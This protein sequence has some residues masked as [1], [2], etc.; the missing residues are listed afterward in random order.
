VIHRRPAG[1]ILALA[2]ATLASA[3]TAAAP[4]LEDPE[5]TVVPELVVRA[6]VPGPAWWTVRK[7]DRV[8]YILGLPDAP[9]P[10][11]LKWDLGAL[12]RRLAGASVLITPI[13]PKAG[14]GD[15]PAFLRM[16][17]ELKSRAPMEQGLPEAL[18][19]RF[20]AARTRL[21]KPASRYAGWDA[22]LAGQILVNDFQGA[23]RMTTKE[24]LAAVRRAAGRAGV[25]VR[26][27]ASFR[28][29]GLLDPA[30]RNLTP[31]ISQVCLV[32][33]LDEV[34][35]GEGAVDAAGAAWGRGDVRG[36]LAGPRGFDACLLLL[37]GGSNFWRQ[38][39]ADYADAV[40]TALARPGHAVAVFPIRSLLAED[41][42]LKRLK[43]RGL[44]V[45][46]GRD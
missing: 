4:A 17:K 18:R 35:A 22:I 42:V 43:A 15:I 5:A 33:A 6:V 20:A 19:V 12:E 23:A 46:G 40:A 3:P 21:G 9:L 30:I 1:W 8:V 2:L 13:E 16:R 25:P 7:G 41:G 27:A 45:S 39:M 37:Q 24:P 38:T 10:K 36:E 11:A 32:E 31:E 34:D 29:V 44:E 26:P 14:L 28:V